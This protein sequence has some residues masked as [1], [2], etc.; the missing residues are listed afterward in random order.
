VTCQEAIAIMGEYLEAALGDEVVAALEH[1]LQDCP[2]CLAYLNT[3]RKTRDLAGA[4]G[5]VA[6]PDEVK[7]RLR[8]L[9]LEQLG[10]GSG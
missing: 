9:L 8:R 4:A 6:M 10:H 3:Y 1:H 5:R 2:P 7:E